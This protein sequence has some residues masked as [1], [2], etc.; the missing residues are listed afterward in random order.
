[1]FVYHAGILVIL[2]LKIKLKF[3]HN[4]VN[5]RNL[6]RGGGSKFTTAAVSQS[7]QL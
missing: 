1:M 7:T 6:S 4:Q 5:F 2:S 3:G